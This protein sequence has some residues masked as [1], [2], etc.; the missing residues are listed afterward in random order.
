MLTLVPKVLKIL[1]SK[2][3][4]F[5]LFQVF[6]FMFLILHSYVL[7]CDFYPI[8]NPGNPATS[9]GLSISIPEIVLII[10]VITFAIDKIR[11]F[12]VNERKVFKAK[13]KM[14]LLDSD[15]ILDAFAI[16]GFLVAEILRFIPNQDCYLAARIILCID[17]LMWFSKSMYGYKFLRNVGPKLYMIRKM[18]NT[19]MYLLINS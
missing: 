11:E 10:W 7:L 9:L 3:I 5:F 6:F 2:Y 13:L 8:D 4:I 17:I 14:F 19:S 18:V 1:N 15:N 12:M 16:F